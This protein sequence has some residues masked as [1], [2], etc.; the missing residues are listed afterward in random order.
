[1]LLCVCLMGLDLS[2]RLFQQRNL[3]GGGRGHEVSML[4]HT[5]P[6]WRSKLPYASPGWQPALCVALCL[7]WWF[8]STCI[9]MYGDTWHWISLLK[10][11]VI[12]YKPKPW[13]IHIRAIFMPEKFSE[14]Q[15][16]SPYI[17]SEDGQYWQRLPGIYPNFPGW[18]HLAIS[19]WTLV[20]D[21]T[22]HKEWMTLRYTVTF[23]SVDKESQQN[24][25]RFLKVSHSDTQKIHA[26]KWKCKCL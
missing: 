24:K 11:G 10:P 19:H 15:N 22:L 5:N 1:M 20:Q 3:R 25:V 12:K 14:H 17:V 21:K 6:C 13:S 9:E 23:S 16:L 18:K 8:A 2:R 26:P 4:T 7:I